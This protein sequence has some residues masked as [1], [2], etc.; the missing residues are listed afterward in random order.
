VKFSIIVD[1]VHRPAQ[2]LFCKKNILIACSLALLEEELGLH[3]VIENSDTIARCQPPPPLHSRSCQRYSEIYRMEKPHWKIRMSVQV[4]FRKMP[5]NG[6]AWC[7]TVETSSLRQS[8]AFL[9]SRP[10]L[11]ISAFKRSCF[12]S[13][14]AMFLDVRCLGHTSHPLYSHVSEHR[15]K[16]QN[17]GSMK[18]FMALCCRVW[19]LK[20]LPNKPDLLDY[21]SEPRPRESLVIRC[22]KILGSNSEEFIW[23]GG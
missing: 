22:D 8:W 17:Q 2:P 11:C 21:G 20:K 9:T 15:K 14:M 16:P 10:S 1:T 13:T 23:V 18:T 19:G 3:S 7:K 12:C 4:R 6:F 5:E